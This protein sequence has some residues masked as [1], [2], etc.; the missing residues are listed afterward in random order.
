MEGDRSKTIKTVGDW[1]KMKV[2]TINASK[3]ILLL[4][5]LVVLSVAKM[6][7]PD[8][9]VVVS[10]GEEEAIPSI[11]NHNIDSTTNDMD[12]SHRVSY[13]CCVITAIS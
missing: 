9:K 5:S 2:S 3:T 12:Q 7:K 10:V 8:S 1:Y 13:I 4:L 11:P 6:D